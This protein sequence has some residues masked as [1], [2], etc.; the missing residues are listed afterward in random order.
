MS[1]LNLNNATD[2]ARLTLSNASGLL[3]QLTGLNN[4]QW[5]IQ[6]SAY[7]HPPGA[8]VIFHI[9]KTSADYNGAVAMVQDTLKRRVVPFKF[10]YVDG[11]TTDDLG[12]DGETFDFDILLFG[13]GYYA[14]YLKLIAEFNKPAPGTL[15]HPVRGPIVAK[16]VGATV[17]HRSETRKAV[18]LRCTFVEHNFEVSFAAAKDTTKSV[19]AKAVAFLA[20][21]ANL[22]NKIDSNLNVLSNVRNAIKAA[23][24]QYHTDYT[25]TL[26]AMNTTF[27]NGSSN[28]IP[29][30]LPNN[31]SPVSS[32]PVL[33]SPSDP[34]SGLTPQQI[35]AAQSPALASLQA[36]DR[37]SA[38]RTQLNG[39]IATIEDAAVDGIPNQ[40]SLLFYDDILDLKSSSVAMQRVLE[41]GLQSSQATI[42]KYTVPNEV[43]SVREVCFANGLS[44]DRSYDLEVLNPDLLSLNLIPRG[45]VVQ[46]PTA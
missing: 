26:V 23:V 18:A 19:L 35:Q 4:E 27:N 9:F 6:E 12:R 22:V 17:T 31:G 5:D 42:K 29:G 43:M 3:N 44:P 13:D 25:N 14:A 15:I 40:G 2:F 39:V 16:F 8:L 1:T 32:F 46:V 11:Q 30:L 33:E 28:D 41:L 38:L 37:V 10:P 36:I 21:I 34:F 24:A 20:T 7:G 45:T